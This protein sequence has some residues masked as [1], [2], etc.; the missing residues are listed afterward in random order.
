MIKIKY[1]EKIDYKKK[2][3]EP[4][5]LK[6][7]KINEI[8][9]LLKEYSIGKTFDE[10]LLMPISELIDI[11]KIGIKEIENKNQCLNKEGL[12][13][14][15]ERIA[16]LFN[17]K[18]FQSKFSDFFMSYFPESK[19]CYYCNLEFINTFIDFKNEYTDKFDLINNFESIDELELIVGIGNKNANKIAKL[20][21]KILNE[22]DFNNAKLDGS[23]KKIL[24]DL[25]DNEKIN[26]EKIK[27]HNHFTLDHILPQKDYP[28]L[29]LS[30]YNLVPC[31]SN[32]NSKFKND[33]EISNDLKELINI[34]PT[35]K[36][37]DLNLYTSFDVLYS[38]NLHSNNLPN[39]KDEYIIKLNSK[40]QKYIETLKLQG[41]YNYHKDISYNMIDQRKIYSDSQIREIAK[42]LGRD[43]QS[44]K[45]DIFGKECFESKN[46]P[47]EKYKQD[48]AKQLGLI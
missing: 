34:S 41:R 39:K 23:I 22:N 21:G 29:S 40:Y 38:G 12:K 36:D 44:I 17:Y 27:T 4:I 15:K 20:K 13:E 45:E 1:P 46:E 10:L 8:N 48:I 26:F 24:T 7:G 16:I 43:E 6:I 14:E 33:K 30:L 18:D 37:F 11:S 42:L 35:S 9:N 5:L 32:C 47:F 28:H 3:S 31:C 19:T 2:Y 25:F